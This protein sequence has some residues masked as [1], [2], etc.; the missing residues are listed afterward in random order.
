MLEISRI[1][2]FARSGALL[3]LDDLAAGPDGVDLKDFSDGLLKESRIDNKL[4]SLPQARSMPVF[5]YN[6]DMFKAAGL[7]DS[8]APDN[9]NAVRD[10]ALKLTKADGSQVGFGLQIGN[11]WWYFQM[12]TENYGAEVSTG[13]GAACKPTFNDP[14]AV[15]ALQWWYDLVNKDKAAK[16]YPG[17]GLTTWEALQ[18]D[19]ISGKVGMMFITTGWMG[20]IETNSK[21]KVGVGMIPAGPTGVRRIPTGGNGIVI[22]IK[23]PKE[24]QAASWKFLKWLTDTPQTSA[25]AQKTGYMPLRLSA[26]KDATLQKYFTERPNFQVAVSQMQYASPFPCIKLNPKTESTLDKLWERIFVGK[27]PIKAVAD[28]V[29]KQVQDLLK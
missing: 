11:P 4:Y 15:E 9:W 5:Y 1:P 29:T 26:M 3:A 28:D 19:F 22:P 20:N 25:W 8:K 7:D 24:K 6:K 14:K 12:A 21:F 13:E 27:E 10:A 17:Q 2:G 18:A 16:I 23:S